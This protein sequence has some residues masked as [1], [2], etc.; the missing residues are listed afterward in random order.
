MDSVSARL[1]SQVVIELVPLDPSLVATFS[2]NYSQRGL[3]ETDVGEETEGEGLF[4]DD[5]G[6]YSALEDLT[7]QDEAEDEEERLEREVDRN[8]PA[9]LEKYCR[10]KHK[11]VGMKDPFNEVNFT[12]L[13]IVLKKSADK[14]GLMVN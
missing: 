6:F 2:S 4:S 7:S 14:S 13:C 11:A 1:C 9:L 8:Y 5:T 12:E 3:V 10:L